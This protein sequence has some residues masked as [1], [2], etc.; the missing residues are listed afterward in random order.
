L[1]RCRTN[2]CPGLAIFWRGNQDGRYFKMNDASLCS[3]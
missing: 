1:V 2:Q 3:E